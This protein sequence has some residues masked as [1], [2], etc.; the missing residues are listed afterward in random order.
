MVEKVR[1]NLPDANEKASCESSSSGSEITSSVSGT[2]ENT[3]GVVCAR[4]AEADLLESLY[5]ALFGHSALAH[6]IVCNVTLKCGPTAVLDLEDSCHL[7]LYHGLWKTCHDDLS[8]AK[9]HGSCVS[10]RALHGPPHRKSSPRT[11]LEHLEETLQVRPQNLKPGVHLDLRWQS[12][13]PKTHAQLRLKF[14]GDGMKSCCTD[15]SVSSVKLTSYTLVFTAR[16]D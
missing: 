11:F 9:T 2:W 15:A 14:L 6:C 16:P 5:W 10:L 13:L 4:F 7:C 1:K 3:S 8:Q 12:S